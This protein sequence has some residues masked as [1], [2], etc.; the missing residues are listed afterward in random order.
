MSSWPTR[1]HPAMLQCQSEAS[2]RAYGLQPRRCTAQAGIVRW[3][4]ATSHVISHRLPYLHDSESSVQSCALSAHRCS[5]DPSGVKGTVPNDHLPLKSLVVPGRSLRLTTPDSVVEQ[6]LAE[7]RAHRKIPEGFPAE[8]MAEARAVE[9]HLPDY[10]LTDVAFVTID[11][12]G[13]RDLDQALHLEDRGEG[14]RVR[15]AIADVAAFVP[16]G[17]ALDMEA[18]SRGLT[19][20][21]PDRRTPLYPTILSE[22]SASLLADEERPAQVWTI[23]LD[24]DGD[25]VLVDF[26]RALVRSRDQ[27]DYPT[28]QQR[29]DTDTAPEPVRL[30]PEIGR[31]RE[32]IEQERGAVSLPIPDQ[33]VIKD[34]GGWDLVY[35]EPLPV[36]G[37][38]AQISLLTGMAAARMMVEAGVGVL[39]TL[40]PAGQRQMK[41][42]RRVA[43]ALEIAWPDGLGYPDLIRS[44]DARI[45]AH[46]ALLAEATSLFSGAGYHVLRV[47]KK[48]LE[49]SALAT[50]YTHCTA[51]LRRLIDRFTGEICLAVS[52]VRDV[53]DW[54]TEALPSLPGI[55][56]KADSFANGYEAECVNLIEAALLSD[57]VGQ[58]FTGVVVE[59]DD[60]RPRGDV[61]IRNPAVHARIEGD[62]FKLGEEI[63][64][65]LVKASVLERHVVFERE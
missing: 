10:D 33:E 35:R 28:V 54:V 63:R 22:G 4:E 34:N 50:L 53:P 3:V 45:P 40:P 46:A 51:P 27:L 6:G 13:A 32:L 25:I 2:P 48:P 38:N 65:R 17:G 18:R 8:V 41:R 44:L 19:L 23:D 47:G 39:R 15:Y 42:L 31:L 62:H 30:L 59:V 16:P 12:P 52:A 64:T 29:L 5:T 49:H 24:S 7:I 58:T 26:R 55:M 37:W 9:P 56:A 11:P 14:Y 60:D 20:Y 36:E 57:R 21:G 1:Q 43:R 61:Q